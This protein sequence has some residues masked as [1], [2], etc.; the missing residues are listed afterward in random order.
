MKA[1]LPSLFA[2][3]LV[4]AA[5]GPSFAQSG[6]GWSHGTSV[7]V[8]AGAATS[9]SDPGPLIGGTLAW[10]V[11]PRVAV[12]GAGSWLDRGRSADGFNAALKLRGYWRREGTSPFAEA[13]FGLYRLSVKPGA[14]LPD[15]YRRRMES[16][17][18]GLATRAFTDPVFHLGAG[19]SFAAS[20]HLSLQ[21]AFETLLVTRSS[22]LHTL[23]SFSLRMAWRFE[24]R[25]VTP[26]RRR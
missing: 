21:P 10:D 3:S 17:P 19:L 11:T 23:V 2:A 12:E 6:N 9:A 13:G 20:R 4:A 24:D 22:R 25:P 1:L 8:V 18:G 26:D 14:D 15:F 16:N 5:A 7:A